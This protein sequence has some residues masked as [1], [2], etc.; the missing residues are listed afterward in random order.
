MPK[1]R[2]QTSLKISFPDPLQITFTHD[3]LDSMDTTTTEVLPMTKTNRVRVTFRNDFHNTTATAFAEPVH[4]GLRL[5]TS[6]VN[7][8]SKKL[9]G[10]SDCACGTFRGS[11]TS[12]DGESY[13]FDVD[14]THRLD[15]GYEYLMPLTR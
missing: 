10:M 8:A 9:C 3:T 13:T 12:E 1:S 11:I 7:R 4:G 6:Q 5:T 14:R 15:D 2:R